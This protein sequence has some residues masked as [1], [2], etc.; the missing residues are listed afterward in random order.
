MLVLLFCRGGGGI[1]FWGSNCYCLL[2]ID[3]K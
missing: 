3:Y 2:V 1:G